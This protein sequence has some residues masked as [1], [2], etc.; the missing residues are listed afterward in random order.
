MIKR[1][2]AFG[3]G[4]NGSENGFAPHQKRFPRGSF[5]KAR[6]LAYD[7]YRM[8]PGTVSAEVRIESRETG[9]MIASRRLFDD[10]EAA[11][12]IGEDGN[13]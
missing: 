12:P 13:H 10:S 7:N 3:N 2:T 5:S 4:K 8:K 11:H 1:H 9:N 6:Q